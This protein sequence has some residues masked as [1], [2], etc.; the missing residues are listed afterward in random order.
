[1][2]G[3]ILSFLK[4][5]VFQRIIGNSTFEISSKKKTMRGSTVRTIES[6]IEPKVLQN[7]KIWGATELVQLATCSNFFY[8]TKKQPEIWRLRLPKPKFSVLL[9]TLTSSNF[10]LRKDFLD[11]KKV[12]KSLESNSFISLKDAVIRPG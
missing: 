7:Q 4:F 6:A 3:L 2:L 11:R 5:C 9:I 1:M 12:L 8:V 10:F